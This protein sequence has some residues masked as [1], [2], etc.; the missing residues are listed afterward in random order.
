MDVLRVDI[1]L[2]LFGPFPFGCWLLGISSQ[3]ISKLA[4]SKAAAAGTV[5]EV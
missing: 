2:V 1:G 5:A 4:R 3:I